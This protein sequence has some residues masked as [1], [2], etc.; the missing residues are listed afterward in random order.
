ME[1][2]FDRWLEALSLSSPH[3]NEASIGASQASYRSYFMESDMVFQSVIIL[4]PNL[5]DRK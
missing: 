3:I 4:H 5:P 2:P 1:D